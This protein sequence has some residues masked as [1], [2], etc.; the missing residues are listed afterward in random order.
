MTSHKGRKLKLI[1]GSGVEMCLVGPPL[2]HQGCL[3]IYRGQSPFTRHYPTSRQVQ[4]TEPENEAWI[5]RLN[6]MTCLTQCK[7]LQKL[8]HQTLTY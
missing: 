3:K 5:A 6:I 8:A 4:L 7:I 2:A 1:T